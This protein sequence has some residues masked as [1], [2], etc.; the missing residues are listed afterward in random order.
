MNTPGSPQQLQGIA[1]VA[2]VVSILVF[3]LLPIVLGLRAARAKGRS[4]HWMWFGLNPI[5]GWIAYLWLRFAA[6]PVW[7]AP[8]VSAA[9]RR[10]AEIVIPKPAPE[11]RVEVGLCE[12]CHRPLRTKSAGLR[13]DMR[14]TCRCGHVNV[15]RKFAKCATCG[16]LIAQADAKLHTSWYDMEEYTEFFC[17]RC[18]RSGDLNRGKLIDSEG[19]PIAWTWLRVLYAKGEKG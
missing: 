11:Q 10:P 9:P 18:F 6:S 7:A 12:V 16:Q 5:T 19:H 2:Y 17:P 4:L 15:I 1:F 13:P 14:L 8:A 3:W